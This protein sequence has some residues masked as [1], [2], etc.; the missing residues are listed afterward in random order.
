MEVNL[1]LIFMIILALPLLITHILI[2]Y[3]IKVLN[4]TF[5]FKCV[6][7]VLESHCVTV[8]NVMELMYIIRDSQLRQVCLSLPI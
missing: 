2:G 1:T 5:T 7:F 6:Y 8:F 3:I 4:T